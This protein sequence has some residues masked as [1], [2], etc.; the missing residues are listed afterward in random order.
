MDHERTGSSGVAKAGMITGITALAL[1]ALNNDGLAGILGGGGG[2]SGLVTLREAELMQQSAAKDS[3]IAAQHAQINT[4]AAVAAAVA[5][6]QT[7]LNALRL[8][9]VNTNNKLDCFI[10]TEQRDIADVYN[11][12]NG[13]FIPQ[14]KGFM[15]GRKINYHGV[16][17]KLYADIK[18]GG[19]ADGCDDCG[20]F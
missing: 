2:G 8:N 12:V 9:A 13:T 14:E 20:E 3:V 6:L 4:T 7:E 1:K 15:D 11:Y 17:P 16:K 19:D 18:R 5:P 10:Q